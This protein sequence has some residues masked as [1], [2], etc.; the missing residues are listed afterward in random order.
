MSTLSLTR[1]DVTADLAVTSCSSRVSMLASYPG[2]LGYKARY[3]CAL[4]SSA[5]VSPL[6]VHLGDSDQ[7]PN[8]F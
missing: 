1:V 4:V 8:G 2:P 3:L 7:A 6:S 5:S